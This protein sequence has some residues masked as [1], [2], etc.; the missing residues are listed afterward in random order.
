MIL[1]LCLGR[2]LKATLTQATRNPAITIAD[3]VR[4]FSAPGSG[5]KVIA[6]NARSA[7]RLNIEETSDMAK[8][9]FII[10]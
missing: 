9:A 10:L 6:D 4:K 5:T 2:V 7:S 1:L 3:V 8:I